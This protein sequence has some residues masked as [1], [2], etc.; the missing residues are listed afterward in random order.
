MKHRLLAA[1]AAA[2]LIAT[3]L[4][5]SAASGAG[6]TYSQDCDTGYPNNTRTYAYKD[7]TVPLAAIQSASGRATVRLLRP[8]TSPDSPDS[9]GGSY[10][11]ATNIQ[12]S[13]GST[14]GM[15]Q[16]GYG[17][18]WCPPGYSE[19]PVPSGGNNYALY[20]PSDS[21]TGSGCGAPGCLATASW[22][23]NGGRLVNGH[24][25]QFSIAGGVTEGAAPFRPL[26]RFCVADLTAGG[27]N[28]CSEI[29][30]TWGNDAWGYQT[31]SSAY[32]HNAWWGFET[33]NSADAIG[34]TDTGNID[35][36]A[37]YITETNVGPNPYQPLT[38]NTIDPLPYYGCKLSR[39][40]GYAA[41]TIN[42]TTAR[43]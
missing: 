24:R 33:Q 18:A 34:V 25:Y 31:G 19:C 42:A 20:T 8:C 23:P 29:P 28:L 36:V 35:L 43:H 7:I 38:C 13:P 22:L 40:S 11:M 30:R 17:A 3:T 14:L 27:S 12:Q 9:A 5:W 16:L 21:A 1:M 6:G 10:V 41:D 37:A 32:G 15:V 4:A 2:A 26:W 39:T